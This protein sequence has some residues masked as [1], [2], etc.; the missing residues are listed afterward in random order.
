MTGVQTCA[1]PISLTVTQ[2]DGE[3]Y[4]LLQRTAGVL[5]LA[6]DEAFVVSD[7]HASSMLSACATIAYEDILTEDKDAYAQ[8]FTEFGLDEPLTVEITYTDG[9]AICLHIGS[10]GPL[11]EDTWYYMT[12]EGDTRLFALSRGIEEELDVSRAQLYPV[13]QPTIHQARLDA[14]TSVSYT[15]LDVYKR[16]VRKLHPASPVQGGQGPAGRAE[17]G[18]GRGRFRGRLNL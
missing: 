14:I 9:S 3:S 18:Q 8:Y 12:V 5:T 6:D 16:Q 17:K 10:K 2:R 11:E 15:H 13:T 4:T 7:R 1:L